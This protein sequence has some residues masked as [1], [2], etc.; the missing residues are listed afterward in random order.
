MIEKHA[1]GQ[2]AALADLQNELRSLKTLLQNR[3]RLL[4]SPTAATG[5]NGNGNGN[6]TGSGE[7]ESKRAADA[8]LGAKRGIPAWQLAGPPSSS[9]SASGKSEEG[10]AKESG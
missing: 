10:E 3:Q 4:D 5:A 7:S 9:A 8:L 1:A 2:T 6:G